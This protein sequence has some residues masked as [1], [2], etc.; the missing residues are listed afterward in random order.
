MFRP[1]CWAASGNYIYLAS[2]TG[3]SVYLIKPLLHQ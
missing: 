3:H 1:S 2:K